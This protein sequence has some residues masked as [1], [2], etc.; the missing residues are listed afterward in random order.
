MIA[1][2]R[3]CQ[4]VLI[5]LAAVKSAVVQMAMTILGAQLCSCVKESQA[6]G[7]S[8]DETM[9]RFMEIFRKFS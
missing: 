5:Q 8:P 2:E 1:D 9:A 4:E 6:A 3:G 7:R